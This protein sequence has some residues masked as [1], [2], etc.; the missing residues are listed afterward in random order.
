MAAETL[1]GE[2]SFIHHDH[3]YCTIDYVQN[4]KK[5]TIN[6]SIS[7]N[8]QQ[9]LIDEKIIKKQH[10][11][12]V[13][14]VVDF[15][16]VRSPRGDKQVADCIQF[17]YNNA[18]D[19]LIN[20]AREANEFIG[21]LKK[22]DEDYFVKETGSYI[23]FPLKLSEWEFR[24]TG[25]L[26]NEPIFFKLANIDNSEKI[27]ATLKKHAYIPEFHIAEKLFNSKTPIE[28]SVFNVS[29]HAVYVNLIGEK[30]RGKLTI[31]KFT[32]K[33]L[34]SPGA[35]LKVIITHFSPSRIVIEL[36]KKG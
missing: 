10:R 21:Y 1:R 18:L 23:F 12:H 27:Y 36:E 5:K 11:F 25:N 13:G 6:G 26:L 32:N 14:D 8:D 29:P 19:N 22:V 31:D 17:F 24:P 15:I 2:I 4:G 33:K 34:P 35:K 9:K 7:S 3:E 30:I 16:I 28:A 20:K